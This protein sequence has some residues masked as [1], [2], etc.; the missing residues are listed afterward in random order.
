MIKSRTFKAA[1]YFIVCMIAFA[2]TGCQETTLVDYQQHQKPESIVMNQEFF[3]NPDDFKNEGAFVTIWKSDNPG[4]SNPDQVTIPVDPNETYLYDIYW[5]DVSDETINNTLAEQT[6]ETTITFPAPGTYRLEITGTFPRILFTLANIEEAQKIL[7]VQQWGAIEWTSMQLAFYGASNLIVEAVDAP[8]LSGVTSLYGMFREASSLNSDF[9][10]WD[11][12]GIEDMSELFTDASSFNGNIDNWDVSNVTEMRN[13]FTGAH[14]FNRDIGSWDV[15]N[16]TNMG[17]MFQSASVF[18]QDIGGWDVSSVTNFR[19]MFVNAVSFNQDIGSWDVSSALDM[20]MMFRNAQQFNR[21]IGGWDVSSVTNMSGM[22]A[23]AISFNQDIGGWDV[24]SVTDMSEMFQVAFE[25]NQDL[26]DWDV[27]LVTDF[28]R[29]FESASIFNRDIGGWDVSSAIDMELMFNIADQFNQDISGWNVSNVI[30]MIA[31]FRSASSFNQDIGGWDV[32]SV[33]DMAE[34]FKNAFDFNQDLGGWIISNVIDMAGML[35]GT[36]LSVENYD[37][38]LIGWENQ[39]VQSDVELGAQGLEYCDGATA[40]Q[41]L[42]DNNDWQISG[43]SIAEGCGTVD[44]SL[45]IVE[46]S[47]PQI[48]CFFDPSCTIIVDDFTDAIQP[49]GY[50]PGGFLQSRNFPQGVSDALGEGLYAY[51]YRVDLTTVRGRA[52]CVK[53]L[54]VDFGPVEQLDYNGDGTLDHVFVGTEGG[55]GSVVPESAEQEGSL[56]TFTFEGQGVC[57]G[58]GRTDGETSYFFGLASENDFESSTATIGLSNGR[59]LRVT[60]RTPQ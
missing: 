16:V 55:L 49:P 39:I 12:S 22:Y 45:R 36:A 38:T 30:N 59:E 25:F 10:H 32:S 40:R 14:S 54:S 21:D 17:F 7:S 57:P 11:V 2:A 13:M 44:T 27:G 50:S 33:T 58:R 43:D 42:I 46:V 34:M 29:M 41:S 15:S 8:D 47:F 51:L 4:N 28:R 23:A 24:S 56:I 9:D 20:A 31:M 53:T 26:G 6:G 37:A 60:A 3:F 19:G 35:D 52:I 48:N 1:R 18:N 5:E